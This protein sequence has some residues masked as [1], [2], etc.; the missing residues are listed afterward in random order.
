MRSRN[1]R[2][3]VLTPLTPLSAWGNS[4]R[5]SLLAERGEVV[6]KGEGGSPAAPFPLEETSP[7]PVKA[8]ERGTFLT[9]GEGGRGWGCSVSPRVACMLIPPR[10][11][12]D[13]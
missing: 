10:R 4:R 13:R 9:P 8:F 2:S 3:F 5:R 11:H 12:D 7:P 6:F 1:V